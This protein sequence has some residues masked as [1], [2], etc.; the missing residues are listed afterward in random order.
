MSRR[1]VYDY[2]GVDLQGYE[3]HTEVC[4]Q[5]FCD[6]CGDCL[7]CY[8]DDPCPDG[9]HQSVRYLVYGETFVPSPNRK[10]GSPRA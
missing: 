7:V 8:G 6:T 5:D 3:E 2:R 10:S 4:G 9:M 1:A